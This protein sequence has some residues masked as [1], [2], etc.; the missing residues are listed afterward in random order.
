MPQDEHGGLTPLA[1]AQCRVPELVLAGACREIGERVIRIRY[2]DDPFSRTITAEEA[3][4]LSVVGRHGWGNFDSRDPGSRWLTERQTTYPDDNGAQ[5]DRESKTHAF[6]PPT[7]TSRSSRRWI[8][9]WLP[10][11]SAFGF[12]AHRP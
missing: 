5:P 3:L 6:R 1:S 12:P 4:R 11:S 9:S 7:A 8:F 10:P 2:L